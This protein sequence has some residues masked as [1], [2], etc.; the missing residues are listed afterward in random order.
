MDVL[1]GIA[2]SR[3][4]VLS[5][6]LALLFS[7]LF[8]ADLQSQSATEL[9]ASAYSYY[10]PKNDKDSWQRLYLLLSSTFINVVNEGQVDLDSGLCKAS[11]SLGLS[12]FTILAEGFGDP[13][14][15]KQSQWIDRRDPGTGAR[16]LSKAKGRTHLQLL[17]LLGSYY[18]FQPGSYQ[19]SQDS[20]KYFL[21]KA[22]EES[23]TLKEEK[24][25]RHALCLLGKIFIEVDEKKGDSIYNL[26]IEQCRQAGDNETEAKA[27]VY[28]SRF[29]PVLASTFQRKIDDSQ[30]AVEKYETL[31]NTEGEINALTDIGYLLTVSGQLQSAHEIF[32]KAYNLAE[33]IHFPYM[34]YNAQALSMIT[35]FQGKFGEPLRYTLQMIKVSENCRDSIGWG[36]FH[37]T[38]ALLLKS[39]GRD[40]ES[41][42][43][44]EKA[45]ERFVK[46]RNPTLFNLLVDVIN[47]MGEQGRAKEALDLAL[48]ISKK[49]NSPVTFADQFFFHNAFA[50]CYLNLNQFGLAQMHINKMDSLETKAEAIRGPLRRSAVNYQLGILYMK[51]GEYR[52]ARKLFEKHFS[53]VSIG[54]RNL[55]SDL[56]IYRRLIYV[57]S[58]L[59]DKDAAIAHYNKYTQL[60]DSNFQVTK[61]R[62]AEELQVKYQINEKETEIVSLTQQA[63]LEKAN[64]DRASLIK[65]LTLAGI[66]AS[67]GV[68][69]LLFRQNRLKQKTN[70]VITDKNQQLE[71]LVTDKER[72]LKDKEWLMKEI[73]HRVKNNL[74]IVMSL[75]NSQSIY[76]D[77]DDALNAIHDT[78]RRVHAMALIHQKLYLSESIAAISMPEYINDLVHYVRDSF[79]T[80]RR[81]IFEQDIER[82][83]LDVSQAIPLG[84]I[85]NEGI[86]NAIKYAFPDGRKGI[87]RINLHYEDAENLVLTIS[88][89]GIGLAKILV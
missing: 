53:T 6:L 86:V 46:D 43:I 55:P 50:A 45:I 8:T 89:N 81:V 73:H 83:D 59:G 87:V 72:L 40:R 32:L 82:I 60:L 21:A 31:G 64:S 7:L 44:S 20:A 68:V 71:V 79:D 47:H 30:L 77:K 22:I 16:L 84:L 27:L 10:P 9:P 63:Q 2:M 38:L 48:D 3:A 25:G 57:D 28:R 74:Q 19:Q 58:V 15:F 65:N 67:I 76:I 24:L 35:T 36:Y 52:E 49:V 34:H 80:G 1:K 62:Q 42:A 56:D 12:R 51:K 33:S 88:D 23:K 29:T 13:E 39:E 5:M 75:L 85:I 69:I 26:L 37:S 41:L 14:L 78:R 70:K 4:V 18:A 54:M 17:L 66:I 11:S 61:I